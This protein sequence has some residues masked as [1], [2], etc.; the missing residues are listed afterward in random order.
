ME[1]LTCFPVSAELIVCRAFFRVLEYFIGLAH[2][3]E[4]LFS[5]RLL[6]H[7][8]MI[9]S[10]KLAVSTLDLVLRRIACDPDYLIIVFKLH[11]RPI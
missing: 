10:G 5:I 1:I 3:L 9:L 11:P 2:F 6:A 4:A 7:I 8:R